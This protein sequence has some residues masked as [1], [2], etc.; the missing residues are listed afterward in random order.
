MLSYGG[1][2]KSTISTTGGLAVADRATPAASGGPSDLSIAISSLELS[3]ASW[4]ALILSSS[5]A[6]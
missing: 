4:S 1:P 2:V 5:S 6:F 3:S